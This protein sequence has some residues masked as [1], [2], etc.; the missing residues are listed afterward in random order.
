MLGN[1]GRREAVPALVRRLAD[2]DADVRTV[3]PEYRVAHNAASALLRLGRPGREAL[4]RAAAEPFTAAEPDSSA[5]P[6]AREAL[7]VA[8]LEQ[9]RRLPPVPP[10]SLP[11]G[12][13]VPVPSATAG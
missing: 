12:Q 9:A 2:R 3:D 5:A 8:D 7:A 10:V 13:P 4:E 11:G 1:L 6:H